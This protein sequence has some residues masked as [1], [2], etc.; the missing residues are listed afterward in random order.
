MRTKHVDSSVPPRP[1]ISV[2]DKRLQNPFG[3]ASVDIQLTEPGWTVRE[4]STRLRPGNIHRAKGLGWVGVRPV[5]LQDADQVGE[6]ETS[7]DGYVVRGEKGDLHLMKMPTLKY[8][9]IQ[10]RKAEL[11]TARGGGKTVKT[12]LAEAAE[13]HY[14]R[15]AGDRV[16]EFVG[17]IIDGKEQVEL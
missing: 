4:F 13:A 14:G 5:E 6:F 7:A 15:G 16:S 1:R 10:R 11:N 3:E 12:E 17:E 2:I 9:T 8:Q